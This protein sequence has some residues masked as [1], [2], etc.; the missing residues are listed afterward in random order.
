MTLI[1]IYRIGPT[2]YRIQKGFVVNGDVKKE[3]LLRLPRN[4][5][6]PFG[7]ISLDKNRDRAIWIDTGMVWL[8]TAKA[9][10]DCF[11][12]LQESIQIVSNALKKI[13]G[14]LIPNAVR[15]ST[16][17]NWD[18]FL[19]G[20]RHFL[21]I[22]NVIEREVTCNLLRLH[23][24]TLIAYSGRAGIEV[25][26]VEQVG[27]RRLLNSQEHYAARYLVSLAPQHLERVKQCLRRDDGVSRLDYLDINP[28]GDTSESISSIELRFIDGQVLL[29][30]VRAQAILIQ[31][32]F[33]QARRLVRDGRRIGDPDQQYLERNRARAISK[34]MQ[35]RLEVEQD[36][37]DNQP[38]DG[39]RRLERKNISADTALLD[40]LESLHREFQVLEVE[41]SEIAPLVLGASLY[42]MGFSG[43]RNE[44]DYFRAISKSQEWQNG[45]WLSQVPRLITE[46]DDFRMPTLLIANEA[47]Y[48]IPSKLIRRWWT[49]ALRYDP[50]RKRKEKRLDKTEAL[51]LASRNLVEALRK[52]EGNYSNS[53]LMGCLNVFEQTAG[54][55]DIDY[56][57]ASLSFQDAQFVRQIYRTLKSQFRLYEL[58]KGWEDQGAQK[59]LN[60]TQ[61]HGICLLSLTV[62]QDQEAQA[63]STLEQLQNKVPEGINIFVF[64]YWKFESNK[65]GRP[66]L[67]VEII[68][69]HPLEKKEP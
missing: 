30:T 25:N 16:E 7:K 68:L 51:R 17:S 66:L 9:R 59:A 15:T 67:K 48:P 26:G 47:R 39:Y 13:G 4:I 56:G 38:R 34:S 24:P 37:R 21:E 58:E 29:S 12:Q 3:E 49:L 41:Y 65:D 23:A 31:A 45:N 46:Q 61:Y 20:D 11:R 60:S 36:R 1:Q 52:L 35:A 33:L 57:L 63:Q 62:G 10:E 28:L 69:T 2:K 54:V 40:L 6:L 32:L 42:Q 50:K 19:C 5:N 27:S 43:L 64:S 44:N 53:D 18:N 55:K 14:V 22:E 8:H